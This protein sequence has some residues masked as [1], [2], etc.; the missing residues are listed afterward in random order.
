ML[1]GRQLPPGLGTMWRGDAQG[2]LEQQMTPVASSLEN[3]SSAMRSFLW[4]QLSRF[5]ED[6]GTSGE[7]MMFNSM[8]R[9]GS[10]GRRPKN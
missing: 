2:L 1:Q 6:G 8:R 9:S 10:M 4:I 3:L 7:D 5:G